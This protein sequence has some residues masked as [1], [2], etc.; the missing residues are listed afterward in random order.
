MSQNCLC[1]YFVTMEPLL[2]V[3]YVIL[4]CFTTTARL[5]GFNL[6]CFVTISYT[7]SLCF[8]KHLA[9]DAAHPLVQHLLSYS[10]MSIEERR[11][12]AVY[13]HVPPLTPTS[14]RTMESKIARESSRIGFFDHLITRAT[15]SHYLTTLVLIV[16]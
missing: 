12:R 11:K 4:Q 6:P 14:I 16:Q 9:M 3:A 13:I 15:L 2:N 10:P 1:V 7:L 5:I 8:K